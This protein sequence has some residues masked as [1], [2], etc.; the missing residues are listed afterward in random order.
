MISLFTL[1]LHA[2]LAQATPI[3]LDMRIY[4]NGALSGAPRVIVNEGQSATVRQE[5]ENYDF[6]F[7][8]TPRRE[9]ARGDARVVTRVQANVTAKEGAWEDRAEY[10]VSSPEGQ[11]GS[12]ERS[13][14]GPHP[15]QFRI[16][17][18]ATENN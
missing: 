5:N 15:Y 4:L 16:E 11:G 2:G 10:A 9:N 6:S 14:T 3:P 1:A 7:T 13:L 12:V 17:F 18:N 8:V